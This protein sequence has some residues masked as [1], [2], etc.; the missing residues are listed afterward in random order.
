ERC[1]DRLFGRP[2]VM[3]YRLLFIVLIFVGTV[4]ELQTVWTFSDIMNGL[5]ALPNLVGLLL[6]S[7]L[8]VRETRVYFARPDWKD[9]TA[10]AH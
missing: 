9:L 1:M 10:E 6:L 4:L 3:P 7:G 8:V 2:A 5:M